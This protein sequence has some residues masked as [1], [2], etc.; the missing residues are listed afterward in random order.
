M[1]NGYEQLR[2]CGR[3][4]GPCS[5]AGSANIDSIAADGASIRHRR[6]FKEV[7]K[8]GHGPLGQ[9]DYLEMALV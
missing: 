3:P 4:C 2:D 6:R 7:F 9:T 8:V 1:S 5:L